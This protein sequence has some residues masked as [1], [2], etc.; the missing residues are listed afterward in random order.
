MSLTV[1]LSVDFDPSMLGVQSSVWESAGYIIATVHSIRETIEC[2][3]LGDFDLVLLGPSLSFEDKERLTFLIRSL[4]SRTPVIC[5]TETA[6]YQDAFADA[7]VENDADKILAT[8]EEVMARTTR[9]SEVEEELL[10]H[11]LHNS[12]LGKGSPLSHTFLYPTTTSS[13]R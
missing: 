12:A 2:F 6:G 5:I 4:S 9:M 8:M 11:P 3:K 7:T 10:Y 1:V 13:R